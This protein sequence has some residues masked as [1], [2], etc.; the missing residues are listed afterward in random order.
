M[1][2]VLLVVS[3]TLLL[4]VNTLTADDK[5]FVCIRQKLLQPTQ[6]QLSKKQKIVSHFFVQFLKSALNFYFFFQKDESNSLYISEN[7]N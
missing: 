3:E 4:F 7:R 5:Y 2:N 6:M 1:E